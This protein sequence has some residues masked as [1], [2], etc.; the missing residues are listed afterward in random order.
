[1]N[2]KLQI[3]KK[4]LILLLP[5]LLLI[6][7]IYAL[8]LGGT[9]GKGVVIEQPTAAINYSTA[10]VNSSDFWDSLDTPA[11][12]LH[13]LLGNL[14]WSVAGH[15]IDTDFMP[16][17]TLSYDIGSGALRWGDLYV[18]DISADFIDAADN[19]TTLGSFVGDGSYLTGISAGGNP[20]DQSLNTT[21]D[22]VFHNMNLTGNVTADYG[23]FDSRV[24]IGGGGIPP[25][26]SLDLGSGSICNVLGITSGVGTSQILR[27]S[28]TGGLSYIGDSDDSQGAVSQNWYF[29]SEAEADREMELEEG[30]GLWIKYNASAN[31]F[32]GK[33]N[34]TSLDDW[35]VFDGSNLDFNDSKLETTYYIADSINVVTG[36]GEGTL[37][38][39]QTYKQ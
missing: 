4:G 26:C 8:E 9:N 15:T 13:N 20:F 2:K 14:A 31:W 27:L 38:D 21:D 10:Y 28:G 5:L 37:A 23:L 6:I 22:V 18:S 19:I 29:N 39:I 17:T 36:V 12:I 3:L 11:D 16:D 32:N 7:P 1:M 24:G 35:N 25:E 33:F 30:V 34:W